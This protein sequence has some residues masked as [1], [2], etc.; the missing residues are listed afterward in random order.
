MAA[1]KNKM[2]KLVGKIDDAV[3]D[4][5]TLDV[6]TLSGDITLTMNNGKMMK[7]LEIVNKFFKKANSKVSVEAFYHVDFD[8]DTV[9]FISEDLGE[10]DLNYVIH[11]NS[12]E[13]AKASRQAMLNFCKEVIEG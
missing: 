10:G 8:Q 2:N 7:P 4:F 12:I 6:I 5:T 11:T 3:T 13:S 1:L 9:Q